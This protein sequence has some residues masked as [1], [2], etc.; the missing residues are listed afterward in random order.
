MGD[1]ADMIIE[2]VL[3]QGCGE[4]MGDGNG[5]P[6][7]CRACMKT[8]DRKETL[9]GPKPGAKQKKVRCAHCNRRIAEGGMQ[10]HMRD[11]HGEGK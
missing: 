9:P 3:C 8:E 10:Q 5:Y 2:G 1:I 11:K 6:Q 7:W 4:Y